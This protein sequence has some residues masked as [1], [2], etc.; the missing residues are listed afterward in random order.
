MLADE[1]HCFL[2]MVYAEDDVIWQSILKHFTLLYSREWN[3][4]DIQ[5]AVSQNKTEVVTLGMAS[6]ERTTEH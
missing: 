4:N 2:L 1:I 5:G 6:S 3:T